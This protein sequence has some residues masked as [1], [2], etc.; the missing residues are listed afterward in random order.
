MLHRHQD[1][2]LSFKS[3]RNF[4]RSVHFF[5]IV[6]CVGRNLHHEGS[7]DAV[8]VDNTTV[9]P[10]RTNT[11]P[12]ACLANCPV[13]IVKDLPAHSVLKLSFLETLKSPLLNLIV[14]SY[15]LLSYFNISYKILNWKK[16]AGYPSIIYKIDLSSHPYQYKYKLYFLKTYF[17]FN[18]LI[19]TLGV[20]ISSLSHCNLIIHSILA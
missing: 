20:L 10:Y 17:I 3:T 2:L 6:H 15:H 7:F 4:T 8:A 18:I 19:I 1:V 16:R 12:F 14:I 11:A 9:S 5:F 13:S